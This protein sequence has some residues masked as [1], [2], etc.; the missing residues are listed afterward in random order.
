MV[1]I[2]EYILT[3]TNTIF[4]IIQILCAFMYLEFW[5]SFIFVLMS[6]ASL[7]FGYIMII[8]SRIKMINGHIIWGVI[9]L[10]G[11]VLFL[12]IL[13]LDIMGNSGNFAVQLDFGGFM[14][15]TFADF[16]ELGNLISRRR[17]VVE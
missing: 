10:L 15:I 9:L 1:K 6:V 11:N 17:K 13:W 4:G 12:S 5:M 8:E 2:Q 14:I 7:A 16:E 3:I